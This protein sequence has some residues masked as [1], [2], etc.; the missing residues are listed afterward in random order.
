MGLDLA[1]YLWE[2]LENRRNY[3]GFHFTAT[4]E[5][6]T[7][8]RGSLRRMELK[9]RPT[10]TQLSPLSRSNEARISGGLKFRCFN[11]LV[12]SYVPEQ[13][14][15]LILLPDRAE[16]TMNMMVNAVGLKQLEAILDDVQA[17]IGD[18]SIEA[19]DPTA[20]T[21]RERGTCL[22]YWPCFGHLAP[23]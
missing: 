10:R 9:G 16:Q 17:G 14:E 4:T 13:A 6:C 15:A 18:M 5:A 1:A 3:P 21:K 23:H 11:V 19:Y 8:L 22:W 2:Y 20:P 12:I 7:L